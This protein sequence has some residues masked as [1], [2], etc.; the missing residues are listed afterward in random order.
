MNNRMALNEFMSALP[1]GEAQGEPDDSE[2][3]PLAVDITFKLFFSRQQPCVLN[4]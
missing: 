4:K 2:C 1:G 3:D